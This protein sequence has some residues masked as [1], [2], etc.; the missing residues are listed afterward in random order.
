[1]D[2]RSAILSIFD[3]Q[4]CGTVRFSGILTLAAL[5]TMLSME[6]WN[7]LICGHLGTSKRRKSRSNRHLHLLTTVIL[8]DRAKSTVI[9][10]DRAKSTVILFWWAERNESHSGGQSEMREPFWWTVRNQQSFCNM[11]LQQVPMDYH[12]L[13]LFVLTL[14]LC[15]SLV[16]L[17]VVAPTNQWRELP[18]NRTKQK[19]DKV[20][21][22]EL[23]N[24]SLYDPRVRPESEGPLVVNVSVLLLSLASPDESSLGMGDVQQVKVESQREEGES[25]SL[26]VFIPPRREQKEENRRGKGDEEFDYADPPKKTIEAIAFCK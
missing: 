1:M 19:T 4:N 14:T 16:A 5:V 23:L 11:R 21:L 15:L 12:S 18:A 9:L 20:I 13:P 6:M 26:L 2:K 22:D 24:S 17:T 25:R 3:Q 8:G 7:S 10:V